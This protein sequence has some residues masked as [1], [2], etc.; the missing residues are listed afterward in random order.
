[1]H[2]GKQ[3]MLC[4]TS[5]AILFV[6]VCVYVCVYACAL[7]MRV[8]VC[9]LCVRV[10]V[11]VCP[12]S[13]L[14]PCHSP[15]PIMRC[16]PL[17]SLLPSLT[18]PLTRCASL[19]AYCCEFRRHTFGELPQTRSGRLPVNRA[20]FSRPTLVPS[21]LN[22]IALD[23]KVSARAKTNKN[24]KRKK[25]KETKPKNTRCCSDTRTFCTIR[26]HTHTASRMYSCA[27]KQGSW[28]QKCV[29]CTGDACWQQ[30]FGFK[31]TAACFR[32]RRRAEP[33]VSPRHCS[34]F[35]CTGPWLCVR[36]CVCVRASV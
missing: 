26:T 10:H 30:A 23:S 20:Q 35:V 13:C 31:C 16:L 1:M 24:K 12:L 17:P 3:C 15:S 6:C 7:C 25:K 32:G 21:T 11:C 8:C 19:V 22:H 4:T 9:A 29:E 34:K 18:L 27:L 14:C 5:M 2:S 33:T 28:A 36:V